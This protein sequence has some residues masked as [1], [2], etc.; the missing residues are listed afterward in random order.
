VD[1]TA[2]ADDSQVTAFADKSH[3]IHCIACKAN[4][5]GG[6]TAT[7]FADAIGVGCEAFAKGAVNFYGF[8]GSYERKYKD[9]KVTSEDNKETYGFIGEFAYLCAVEVKHS[10][11]ASDAYAV[12]FSSQL[13]A[14]KCNANA[15]GMGEAYGF[16]SID[17]EALLFECD[18]KITASVDSTC[19]VGSRGDNCKL[20]NCTATVEG[21]P[22]ATHV[23]AYGFVGFDEALFDSCNASISV[24]ATENTTYVTIY[25]FRDNDDSIFNNCTGT[26]NVNG[27]LDNCDY[28]GCGFAKN[29]NAVYHSCTGN[30]VS[31]DPDYPECDEIN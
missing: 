24:T 28:G 9:C 2:S 19:F 10:D 27:N 14:G 6:R 4:L 18:V 17:N 5:Q 30:R 1:V 3:T 7:G 16:D 23:Y 8:G 15:S 26:V 20:F 25:G 21:T 29:D 11:P 22:Q 13:V 12:C 31:A